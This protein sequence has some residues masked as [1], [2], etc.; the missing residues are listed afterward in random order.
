MAR[1]REFLNT[2]SGRSV[3]IAILVVGITVA[4][5]NMISTF[6]SPVSLASERIF[7]CEE[8]GKGFEYTLKEGVML[9]VLSPHSGKKTGYPAELCFWTAGGTIKD[10][11][12]AVR[13]PSPAPVFCPDCKRQVR[14]YNPKPKAGD[15]PPP[16]VDEPK[17]QSSAQV[18]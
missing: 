2:V 3:V 8:T 12:T 5:S 1:V 18:R 10:E 13:L 15:N 9:P 16:T 14:P 7:I 11:P 4:I 17:T 6:S